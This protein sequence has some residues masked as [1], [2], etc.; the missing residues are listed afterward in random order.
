MHEFCATV[1]VLSWVVRMVM[2]PPALKWGLVL[3]VPCAFSMGIVFMIMYYGVCH[4][5]TGKVGR[6][7]T[8]TQVSNTHDLSII[9]L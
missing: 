1:F 4:P 5:V 8:E 6:S 3:A 2:I 7:K 9:G